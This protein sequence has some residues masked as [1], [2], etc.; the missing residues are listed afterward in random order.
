MLRWQ[1]GV[2]AVHAC[3]FGTS[4]WILPKL[5]HTCMSRAQV[6]MWLVYAIMR[7]AIAINQKRLARQQ[8]AQDRLWRVLHPLLAPGAGCALLRGGKQ[9]PV[10]SAGVQLYPFTST[11]FTSSLQLQAVVPCLQGHPPPPD[12][13]V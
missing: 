6:V 13:A 12:G 3:N 2:A 1:F 8:E 11:S 10:A 4:G 5:T 7:A 9:M